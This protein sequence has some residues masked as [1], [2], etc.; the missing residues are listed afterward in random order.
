MQPTQPG[1]GGAGGPR[2]WTARPTAQAVA[3]RQRGHSRLR[4]ATVA[5]GA[6][7]LAVAGVVAYALPGSSHASTAG[8]TGSGAASQQAGSSAGNSTGSSASSGSSR[9]SGSDDTGGSGFSGSSG[10]SPAQGAGGQTTSGGS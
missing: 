1:P 7:G 10:I 4:A 5:V 3:A 2:D 9:S 8:A 6:A